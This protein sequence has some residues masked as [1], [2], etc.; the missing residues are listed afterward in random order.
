M[1]AK[2]TPAFFDN[3]DNGVLPVHYPTKDGVAG[4]IFGGVERPV[5]IEIDKRLR[6][7]TVGVAGACHGEGHGRLTQ[8]VI[9]LID[10]G[11]AR[12]VGGDI[13]SWHTAWSDTAGTHAM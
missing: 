7:R 2:V 8:A 5:V 13:V 11:V 10:D 1:R 9:R 3:D 6:R 4:L 12:G